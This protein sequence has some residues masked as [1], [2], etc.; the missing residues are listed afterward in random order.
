MGNLGQSHD[1]PVPQV[2]HLRGILLHVGA[3]FLQRRCH[4]HDGWDI[5]RPRPLSPLLGPALNQA[6]QGHAPTGVQY[7]SP[8]GSVELVGGKRQQVDVLRLHVDRQV[9]RRLYCIGMEQDA[10]LPAHRTDLGDGQDGAN[11]IVG[12]HDG[13]QGGVLPDGLRHLLGGNGSQ[14]S[15]GKQFY[16]ETL[17][18]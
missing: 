15:H 9:P 11:L 17:A 12:I 18:L 14:L 3:G 8:L 2:G 16:L 10:P 1:E 5:L 4:A 13:H 6:G 7:P